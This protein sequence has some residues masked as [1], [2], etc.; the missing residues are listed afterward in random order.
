MWVKT[1]GKEICHTFTNG[2][3]DR[4]RA[5]DI[6]KEVAKAADLNTRDVVELALTALEQ[7]RPKT[8]DVTIGRDQMALVLHGR[9]NIEVY[10]EPCASA[11]WGRRVDPH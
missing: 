2:Q 3:E 9:D 7:L 8:C 1:T 4:D 5:C 10:C 6:A 11:R